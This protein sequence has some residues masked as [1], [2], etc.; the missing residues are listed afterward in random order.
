MVEWM[1]HWIVL[2][3]GGADTTEEGPLPLKLWIFSEKCL[4]FVFQVLRMEHLILKTLKFDL[5]APTAFNFLERYVA[6]ANA[7]SDGTKLESLA[8]VLILVVLWII[9]M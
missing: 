1:R 5:S 2:D 6:A 4:H 8:K 7:P 9:A 3:E